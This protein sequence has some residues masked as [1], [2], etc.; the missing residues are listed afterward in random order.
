MTLYAS[1]LY[2]VARN[3]KVEFLYNWAIES[4]LILKVIL[5]TNFYVQ[6]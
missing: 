4:V 1:A 5:Y 6:I 3:R 2:I